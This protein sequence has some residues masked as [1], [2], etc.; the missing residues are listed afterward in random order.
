MGRK[1]ALW[2]VLFFLAWTPLGFLAATTVFNV[3]QT[4]PQDFSIYNT[5]WNGTSDFRQ[6][7]EGDGYQTLAI[8]SSMSVISRYNGSAVLV[9]LGPVRDFSIDAVLT[10]SDHLANG[11]GV[12]LA[13]DFGTSN[14]SF[15]WLNQFLGAGF[16]AYLDSLGVSGFISFTGGVLYDLDNYDISPKLPVITRANMVSHPIL[17]GVDE[18]H[19]NWATAISPTC[20]LGF[21]GVAFTSTRT[22][23][24][25]NSSDLNPSPD[26]DEYPGRLPVVGAL[27]MGLVADGAGR[28]VAVSDPSVFTN[29]MTRRFPD[30]SQF[31]ANV[32]NWLSHGNSS[33]P[34]IFCEQLLAT[35]VLSGEFFYGSFLGRIMWASTNL[36]LAPIYPLMTAIGIKK[37][38]PDM[39]KPEIKSVSEVFMRKGQTYFGERMSYYRTEGNYARVVK[40][41]YRKLR[42]SLQKKY[43]WSQYEPKKVWELIRVKDP[44]RK[45]DDF[46]KTISRINEVS[47]RPGIKIK[48]NEMMRLFFWMK[49]IQDKLI[50]S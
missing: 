40:M 30:N 1:E 43:Q 49:D 7:I 3:N 39:K 38:L 37:Y 33:Q 27:D 42:R 20:A 35:P 8:Q 22:W 34:V 47:S 19:L 31:A 46:Y 4:Y 5:S 10:I 13:D 23:V 32:I 45:E 9:I 16:G 29:D 6:M 44:G 24:E 25:S 50:E 11:G 36:W 15:Y 2:M 26:P 18:L 28:F 21:G 48:E 17:A 14:S 41:L 12:L